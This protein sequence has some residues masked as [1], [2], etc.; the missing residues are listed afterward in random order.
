MVGEPSFDIEGNSRLDDPLTPD[1][2]TGAVSYADRGAYEYQAAPLDHIAV[3]PGSPTIQ[4]GASQ[5]FTVQGFDD[6]GNPIGDVTASATLTIAPDGSCTA[7]LCTATIAGLHSIT[8]SD[9]TSGSTKT[10]TASLLVTAALLDHVVLSPSVATI[11][12]NTSQTYAAEG[13]DVYDNSLGDVT[14]ATSFSIVPNGSCSG[15]ACTATGAGAHTVTGTDSGKTG[16]ASLQVVAS[17]LDHIV[18]APS[19][20]TIVG[21]GSRAYS[22]EGFDAAGNS[23][24]DVTA[25]TTFSISPDGSC[26]ANDCT[27]T[28]VGPH[29]VTG[30]NGG[31]TSTADLTVAAAL[32][33]H[34]ALSPA[35]FT[36]TAGGSRAFTAQGRDQYDNPLGDVTSTTTY[37]IAPDGTCTGDVCTASASGLHTVTGTNGGV[38]GTASLRVDAAAAARLVLSPASSAIPVGDS[39]TYTAEGRDAYDNST[40]DMTASVTFAIAPDGSCA[41]A[42]CTASAAGAHTV[43][44][45]AP[46]AAGTASLTVL[47]VDHIV[48]SPSDAS[49]QAGGS[50][51]YTAEGFDTAGNSLGDV[52]SSTTFSIDPDGSCTNNVCTATPAWPHTVTAVDDGEATSTSLFVAPSALDHLV[53]SADS[54]SIEAGGSETFAADGRD[55]FDNSTGDVTAAATFSIAPDG[56][57]SG[58]TCTASSAG[59]HTVTAT[60]AGKTGTYALE[61]NPGVLDHLALTPASATIASGGSQQFTAEARDAYDNSLGDA[62]GNATFSIS[63]DGSCALNVCSAPAS[64]AHTVTATFLGA[65][66]SASLNVLAS[67]VDHI[68]IT[69][70]SASITAGASQAYSVEAFDAQD[71]SLGDVTASAT[72]TSAP[73]GS[74]TQNTCIMTSAG[75]HIITAHAAGQSAAAS[76]TVNPA[77]LDHLVLSPASAAIAAGGSQAFTA[78]GRDHFDNSLGDVTAATVFTIGP[79]GSCTGATCTASGSGAHTVTGTDAGKTGTAAL[80][81]GAGALDHITISPSPA[82]ITA[83]SSQSYTAVGFDAA[84][85]SLGDVSASSTFTILPDGSCS[86][87]SC[88]ATTVG[89]HTVTANDGGKTSTASLTV[90]PAVLDHLVLSPASA[91]ITAGGSQAFTAQGR[92]HF[93]NSLG[94]VTAA[95]VFTI[96]PNGSCTGATCTASGSGAHTVTG[97]DAGK[98]GTAALQVGAG[99]LDHITISPSPATITAGSSQSYTAV[100]FDAAN[101]SLGDVSASS[102]FTIL[103]DGSCSANSCTATTVGAHTVTAN[104][105]GKTSTASLTVNPAVLDHLVLSPASAAITAGGSQAFTAQARDRFD[106]SLGD[107]TSNTTFT[108]GPNGSCAGNICTATVAGTH[109]VSG[110]LVGASGTASM[111]VNKGGLDHIVISPTSA[112]VAVGSS[113]TYNAEGFDSF[114]NSLGSVTP[115]T[116]FTISPDGSC[117]GSVCTT[118]AGGS[119]TVTG[120][121]SGKSARATLNADY[122]TNGG[123]ETNLTGWNASGSGTG[124]TLTRVAGGHSGGWSAQLTNTSSTNQGCTFNDSPNWVKSTL[125][126]TYIATIWVRADRVGAPFKLRFREYTN[127]GNTLVGTAQTQMTLTTS[128]QQLTVSYTVTSPGSTLDLNGYLTTAD[129]APGNCFYADDVSVIF[130]VPV[131]HIAISPGTATITA[132]GSQA[133]TAQGFDAANNS[134]GDLTG[135]TSFTISPDGSCIGNTCTA[136]APG[137]HTVTGNDGGKTST[138]SLS[139]VVGALDHLTLSPAL[140]TI[141][142]G[143]SQAY[144]A[145]GFDATN[146]PL[147]DATATTTFTIAP[148]GSCTGNTCTASHAGPHTI[149]GSKSGKTATAS[150]SVIAGGVDHLALS[151]ASASISAG[152]SKAYTAVGFDQYN[153]SIGDVSAGTT[154]SIAPDGSCN[155][156]TCTA[157][158]VGAHTV[159]GTNSGKTGTASLQVDSGALARIT[160]SP[161]SA[162]IT[163]GSSQAYTAQGFDAANNPLGDVTASTSFT[164]APDGSCSGNSCTAKSAG[165]HTV[166]GSDGGQTATATLT[167]TAASLDHLA[168]SPATA[169]ISAGGSQAYTAQGRDQYDNSLGELTASTTF[170]VAPD[171]SCTGNICTASTAGAHTITGTSIGASGTAALNVV[172]GPSTTSRSAPRARR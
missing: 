131:D 119:H 55:Q 53:L 52:T 78:Q 42:T 6:A 31:K 91:A 139:V 33:D 21:G 81:V 47:S 71:T 48:I 134:L 111:Q 84:N 9:H 70:S 50:Q 141:T 59:S 105:G 140:A 130:G 107:A 34:L 36:I 60:F 122:V 113:Q 108:I 49:I 57:C 90:N 67:N 109:A 156:A 133:F 68:V 28:T 32:L 144:A 137:S 169:T 95:T 27:A 12:S 150:L 168:L 17:A 43:T 88:T 18:I 123:F 170:T 80:Q 158:V 79:N 138:A 147:G 29:T 89:A 35:S 64:G 171:G 10:A 120:T 40:G 127:N 16:T 110:T 74:C 154:F 112:T 24:G 38:S 30:N 162:T 54:S 93:D 2:G 101:N 25:G 44:A 62:T 41:G 58:A 115:A 20:A 86:A 65:T 165:P 172:A 149:T 66:G 161:S 104:D 129:S 159:T 102:T 121:D 45:A 124:V 73:D 51:A 77:V 75:A 87:N 11:A 118:V 132:G 23:V 83:G 76:L 152:G 153:N 37:T 97:T 125:A 3:T 151:P 103:P 164:I 56:S 13:R 166:T 26:S 114:N 46:G 146:N 5:A 82:T 94:D 142:A 145:Q 116:T 99:A 92:D 4:A 106:N 85:N 157:S 100:G 19:S 63:P 155:A 7:N 135:S 14:P 98:T 148:D 143:G 128:W 167:I 96:G 163:A 15:A 69:P 136:S 160:I 61:V 1:T 8:A 22:A 126:G 39:Q 72:F 117:T